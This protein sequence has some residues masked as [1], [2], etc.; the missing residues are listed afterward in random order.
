MNT[1]FDVLETMGAWLSVFGVVV[2]V[3]WQGD[4]PMLH[5]TSILSY[6]RLEHLT[7]PLQD[8][9]NGCHKSQAISGPKIR[10]QRLNPTLSRFIF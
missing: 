10:V 6:I 3:G 2:T 8:H 4:R 1:C 9:A 5:R 7:Q